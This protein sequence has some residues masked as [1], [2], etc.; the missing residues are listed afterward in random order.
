[1]T[2]PLTLDDL[3]HRT[4]TLRTGWLPDVPHPGLQDLHR[5]HEERVRRF[6][7]AVTARAG[8]QAQ[9]DA[10]WAAYK[11]EARD[12]IRGGHATPDRPDPEVARV[13]REVALEDLVQAGVDLAHVAEWAVGALRREHRGLREVVADAFAAVSPGS[14]E[15][16]ALSAELWMQR[17]RSVIAQVD[18]PDNHVPSI[19][20]FRDAVVALAPEGFEP[21]V[22]PEL[23]RELQDVVLPHRPPPMVSLPP[24]SGREFDEAV[25]VG[26]E[27]REN[28]HVASPESAWF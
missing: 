4:P 17:L 11:A 22:S 6:E 15:E 2:P 1:M 14:R 3:R 28:A 23:V 12:A 8:L 13:R 10:A 5:I 16:R 26:E 25:T 19:S 24:P 21:A 20:R 27:F 9:E 18:V 7:A